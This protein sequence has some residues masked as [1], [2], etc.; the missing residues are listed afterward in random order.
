M[1]GRRSF[2]HLSYA[3]TL[4]MHW[5]SGLAAQEVPPSRPPDEII[6]TGHRL[7]EE[8]MRTQAQAFVRRVAAEPV[9]DQFARWNHPLCL[10]IV[11]LSDQHARMVAGSVGRIASAAGAAMAADGCRPT[12]IVTFTTRAPEL[13]ARLAARRS[14]TFAQVPSSERKQLLESDL[15]VRWWSSSRT[16][17]ADGRQMGTASAALLTM[18]NLPVP[19]SGRY[20]DSYHS[21]L[22][23]TKIRVSLDSLS[24]VVDAEA[25]SGVTLHA[26]SSYIAMVTLAPMRMTADYTDVTSIMSLFSPNKA[27]ATWRDLTAFDRAYLAA[28]YRVPADR[29]AWQQRS[30]L[31]Q[32][33]VK[34]F[35]R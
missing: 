8:Q 31:A 17:S 27:G 5:P 32:D 12:V 10:K 3:A 25:A 19:R 18:P 7:D 29:P 2:H 34:A 23:S 20:L 35:S 30:L 33:M 16:E 21:S 14:S 6:V 28:L 11:G 1:H 13:M 15:P 22:I 26:L 9:D 24:I 4:A